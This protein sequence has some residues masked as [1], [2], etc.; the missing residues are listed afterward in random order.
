MKKLFGMTLIAL[1]GWLATGCAA[2]D[3][4]ETMPSGNSG[5]PMLA[6]QA[7][8]LTLNPGWEWRMEEMNTLF[9]IRSAEEL[10]ARVTGG[11]GVAAEVDFS[12][13]S[14]LFASGRA[15][16]GIQQILKTYEAQHEGR[17]LLT[18]E[19]LLNDTEEAP[20]WNVAMLVPAVP[21]SDDVELEVKVSDGY[22]QAIHRDGVT[23]PLNDLT[24]NPGW[25]WRTDE[26]TDLYIIRSEDQMWAHMKKWGS[27]LR[28]ADIDFSRF[29]VLFVP[30]R[31][32]SNVA[33][34]ERALTF[35]S[36]FSL[37]ITVY[38]GMLTVVEDWYVAVYVASAV[39]DSQLKYTLEYTQRR[40]D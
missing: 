34:L 20:L 29:A 24:L 16:N 22:D 15:T 14:V 38:Q 19:L 25:E 8:D 10:A 1:A 3:G 17:N 6:A 26:E 12:R 37:D 9:V 27:T 39:A 5:Q 31:S 33:K 36:G 11:E 32:G 35:S 23:L 4:N 2:D 30:G 40:P 7:V 13:Y 21:V 28:P 18:V